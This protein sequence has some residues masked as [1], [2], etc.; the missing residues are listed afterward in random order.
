MYFCG[1][2]MSRPHLRCSNRGEGECAGLHAARRQWRGGGCGRVTYPFTSNCVVP[3]VARTGE[4]FFKTIT[5]TAGPSQSKQSHVWMCCPDLAFREQIHH[6]RVPDTNLFSAKAVR[7]RDKMS[8]EYKVQNGFYL[9][10]RNT[11]FSIAVIIALSDTLDASPMLLS[12]ETLQS[13][14]GKCWGVK[15]DRTSSGNVVQG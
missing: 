8:S 12:A 9:N 7:V 4:K 5:I 14:L 13:C 11:H 15:W 1:Y 2:D 6:G 3:P 10:L